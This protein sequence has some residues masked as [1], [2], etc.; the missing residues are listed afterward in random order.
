MCGE[1]WEEHF[2]GVGVGSVQIECMRTCA[3][4]VAEGFVLSTYVRL[5]AYGTREGGIVSLI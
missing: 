4:G 1:E 3:K 5:H 2:Q